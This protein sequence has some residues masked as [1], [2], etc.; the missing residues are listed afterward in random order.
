MKVGFDKIKQTIAIRLW[1]FIN[2]PL[3]FQ[4]KPKVVELNQTKAIICIPLHR[5]N[6]N[7]FNSL[8]MGSLVGGAD[9]ACGILAQHLI[10]ESGYKISIIFKGISANFH[11]RIESDAYFI[12]KDSDKIKTLIQETIKTGK[13]RNEEISVTAYCPDTFADETL[14]SFKLALSVRK[15]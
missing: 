14:A 8:Y 9:L 15:Q 10:K 11:K 12:C 2:V 13:R 6:K 3:L 1:S 5:K 4:M 7:H